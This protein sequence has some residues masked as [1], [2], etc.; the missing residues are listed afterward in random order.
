MAA[1]RGRKV[2]PRR[3]AGRAAPL[4]PVPGRLQLEHRK[5][6]TSAHSAVA[7]RWGPR[8]GQMLAEGAHLALGGSVAWTFLLW[9]RVS[10][11]GL[12]GAVVW[13]S[14]F[15]RMALDPKE[16][17]ARLAAVKPEDFIRGASF[18]AMFEECRRVSPQSS[19]AL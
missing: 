5:G 1:C 13:A 9:E 14:R 4:R 17:E 8:H 10:A 6:S 19:G 7:C 18:R 2:R 3:R 16:L 11:Q 12:F 15:W